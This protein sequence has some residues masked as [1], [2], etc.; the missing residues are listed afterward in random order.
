MR[1]LAPWIGALALVVAGA[2]SKGQKVESPTSAQVAP[3]QQYEAPEDESLW[4]KAWDAVSEGGEA[5]AEAGE[6]TFEKA[7]DGAIVVGRGVKK[8]AGEVGEETGDAAI[9]TA[10]KARL[11]ENDQ[12]D[13]ARIDADKIGRAS[14]R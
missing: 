3:G 8:V 5:V 11:A 6:W 4:S 7:K 13:A 9:H 2:C 10:L 1:R 14:R 12:V